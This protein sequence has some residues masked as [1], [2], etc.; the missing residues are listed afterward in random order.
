MMEKPCN[1]LLTTSEANSLASLIVNE[2][3][4]SMTR[5]EPAMPLPSELSEL[6]F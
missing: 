2:A 1:D 5:R 4:S 6:L 3:S